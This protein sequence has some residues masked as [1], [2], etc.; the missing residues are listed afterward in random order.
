M[1]EGKVI[2][3]AIFQNSSC[4]RFSSIDEERPNIPHIKQGLALNDLGTHHA[5]INDIL[6]QARYSPKEGSTVSSNL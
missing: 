6:V 1:G 5:R 4:R 2:G 3:F